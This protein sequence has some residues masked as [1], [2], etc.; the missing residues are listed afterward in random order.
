MRVQTPNAAFQLG[1]FELAQHQPAP[2]RWEWPVDDVVQQDVLRGEHGAPN[3][4]AFPSP[5]RV[6]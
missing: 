3:H 6:L 1:P 5:V 2:L 4:F